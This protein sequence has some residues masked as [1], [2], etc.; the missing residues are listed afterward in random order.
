[1]KTPKRKSFKHLTQYERDRIEKL[2]FHCTS[3]VDIAKILGRDKGTISRELNKHTNK[4]HRYKATKAQQL[5]EEKR[6]G[7][8]VVGMK[9]EDML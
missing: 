8:K 1:M 5:A 2:C 6:V 4:H 3:I 9:I 7:S